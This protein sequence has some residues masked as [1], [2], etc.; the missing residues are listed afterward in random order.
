MIATKYDRL[1]IGTLAAINE[2]NLIKHCDSGDMIS[3]IKTLMQTLVSAARQAEDREMVIIDCIEQSVVDLL[4]CIESDEKTTGALAYVE[5]ELSK[6]LI[7]SG[8]WGIQE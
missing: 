6:A 5:D 1:L 7:F 4:N 2:L 8:S 3:I